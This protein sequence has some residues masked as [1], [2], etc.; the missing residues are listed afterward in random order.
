MNFWDSSCVLPLITCEESSDEALS[1]LKAD[2]VM[3][4]WWATPI[5]CVSALSRKEREGVITERDVNESIKKLKIIEANNIL[6]EPS[7]HLRRLSERLL[8]LHDLRAADALQL[9]AAN[10]IIEQGMQTVK[11]ISNDKR[12]LVAAS[13]E[14]FDVL[15]FIT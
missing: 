9:A 12:L 8:R 6:V 13:K 14:G 1:A 5:E 11:F 4:L 3:I 15:S 10:I 2:S 7:S